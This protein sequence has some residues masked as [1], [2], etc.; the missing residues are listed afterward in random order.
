MLAGLVLS[1][2][3]RENCSLSL[4]ASVGSRLHSY[5]CLLSHIASFPSMFNLALP[6]KTI[7]DFLNNLSVARSLI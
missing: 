5:I 6:Y 1:R 3:S 4:S 2:Y 7:C